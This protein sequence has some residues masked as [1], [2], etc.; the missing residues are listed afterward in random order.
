MFKDVILKST[1]TS[2]VLGITAAFFFAIKSK[3]DIAKSPTRQGNAQI[4]F[5]KIR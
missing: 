1:N 5:I 3:K 2:Y 4:I